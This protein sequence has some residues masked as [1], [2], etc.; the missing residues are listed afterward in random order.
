MFGVVRSPKNTKH[1]V[2]EEPMLLDEYTVG[3]LRDR[4]KLL[5]EWVSEL[6]EDRIIKILNSKESAGYSPDYAIKMAWPGW[7]ERWGITYGSFACEVG[8]VNSP[9]R[10]SKCP[11]GEDYCIQRDSGY[12]LYIDSIARGDLVSLRL[13]ALEIKEAW[14]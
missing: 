9:K 3:W 13:A 7:G 6:T 10:C 12:S 8:G 1:A 2:V 11:L 14:K 5:W 4:H